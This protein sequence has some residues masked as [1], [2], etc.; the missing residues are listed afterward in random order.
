MTS[1][2]AFLKAAIAAPVVAAFPWYVEK[3][4]VA[5]KSWR[6]VEFIS[7]PMP[8]NVAAVIHNDDGSVRR[9]VTVEE[10]YAMEAQAE[11]GGITWGGA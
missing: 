2:R 11:A 9:M 3:P 10:F 8:F 1:R 5:R 4:L 7:A 6:D